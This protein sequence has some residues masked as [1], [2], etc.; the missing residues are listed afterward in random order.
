VKA[1]NSTLEL[2]DAVVFLSPYWIHRFAQNDTEHGHSPVSIGVR[3]R[4]GCAA[5]SSIHD[6]TSAR[7]IREVIRRLSTIADSGYCGIF[8]R[9]A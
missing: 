1:T 2:S 6:A 4:I 3:S 9:I 5:C 7:E 8:V